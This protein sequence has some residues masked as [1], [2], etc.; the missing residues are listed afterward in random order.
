[1]A[2]QPF[3]R[4]GRC[5]NAEIRKTTKVNVLKHLPSHLDLL[6]RFLKRDSVFTNITGTLQPP[7]MAGVFYIV[8]PMSN[9]LQ[10]AAIY[11]YSTNVTFPPFTPRHF[12]LHYLIFVFGVSSSQNLLGILLTTRS[13]T[14]SMWLIAQCSFIDCIHSLRLS[15]KILQT[16][17]H[18]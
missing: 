9:I 8:L 16:Q 6:K 3:H 14:L 11:S 1:M 15:Y 12:P 10:R 17:W 13:S 7:W 5:S 18:R 2:T 4:L